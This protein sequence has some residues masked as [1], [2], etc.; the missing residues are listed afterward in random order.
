MSFQDKIITCFDCSQPFTFS[1][2]EQEQSHAIG[3]TTA[4]KRCPECHQAWKEQRS[5]NRG[6]NFGNNL[7]GSLSTR[8]GGYGAGS[9]RQMFPAVCSDCGKPT[10]VPFEPRRGKPVR[11]SDCYRKVR[12]HR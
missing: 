4:P 6:D 9:P 1:V 11:C 2:A 5:D 7:I 12:V 8:S 10:T 3:Y